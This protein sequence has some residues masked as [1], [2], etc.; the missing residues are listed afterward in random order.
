MSRA[1]AKAALTPSASSTQAVGGI[2]YDIT[3]ELGLNEDGST[4][5][6]ATVDAIAADVENEE[7][8]D[9]IVM[10]LKQIRT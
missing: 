1:E 8:V 3:D 7:D 5:L 6:I 9:E 10:K 4:E 2:G